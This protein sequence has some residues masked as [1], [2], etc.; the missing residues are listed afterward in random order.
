MECILKVT[1]TYF[2][3]SFFLLSPNLLFSPFSYSFSLSLPLSFVL[4]LTF[5]LFDLRYFTFGAA[6]ALPH[7]SFPCYSAAHT[8]G[9]SVRMTILGT[10]FFLTF[11]LCKD[12]RCHVSIL[13]LLTSRGLLSDTPLPDMERAWATHM[14]KGLHS[15][16]AGIRTANSMSTESASTPVGSFWLRFVFNLVSLS[17]VSAN[18]VSR[19]VIGTLVDFVWKTIESQMKKL[20]LNRKGGGQGRVKGSENVPTEREKREGEMRGRDERWRVSMCRCVAVLCICYFHPSKAGLSL[21]LSRSDSLRSLSILLRD[22]LSL[23][24]PFTFSFSPSSPPPF[25]PQSPTHSP[26]SHE[27]ISMAA[28]HLRFDYLHSLNLK[29]TSIVSGA[30]SA[31]WNSLSLSLYSPL[32]CSRENW[33]E[34]ESG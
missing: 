8:I 22:S 31:S 9:R 18:E 11:T 1:L 6:D 2:K 27:A 26:S 34:K 17:T 24:D 29:L 12:L 7:L 14:M 21:L 23:T 10:I 32:F 5:S 20:E 28:G 3:Y 4:F 30:L 16:L 25:S 19:E 33:K 13:S 15:N